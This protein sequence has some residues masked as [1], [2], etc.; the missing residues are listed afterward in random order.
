MGYT[1]QALNPSFVHQSSVYALSIV[2]IVASVIV[3]CLRFVA[4][5]QQKAPL[6]ADDYLM[7]AAVV[8]L[9]AMGS[10]LIYGAAH[11]ALGVSMFSLPEQ[12]IPEIAMLAG[13]IEYTSYIIDVVN[14]ALTKLSLIFFYRR[15]F[16]T[17]SA[18]TAYFNIF[19]LVMAVIVGL[20][21]IIMVFVFIF[22]C[23][24]HMNVLWDGTSEQEN[25]CVE[26]LPLMFGFSLTDMIFDFVILLMP[27]PKVWH[28]QLTVSR[29]ISLCFV[30]ALGGFACIGALMRL[31]WVIYAWKG[32]FD[33]TLDPI[34]VVT[35]GLWWSMLES[36]IAAVA[37]CALTLRILFTRRALESVVNSIRSAVS[38]ASMGS[39]QASQAKIVD[40]S[41][42]SSLSLTPGHNHNSTTS[43]AGTHPFTNPEDIEAQ[44]NI[45]RGNIRVQKT[46]S[47]DY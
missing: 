21:G 2:L 36:G 42:A 34:I 46:I 1:H 30:F 14:L 43:S 19:T 15:I 6:L 12:R 31:V 9:L 10:A 4:R 37:A 35:T 7:L 47:S 3:T 39:Q 25:V 8:F 38:L 26:T 29:K 45:P 27:L 18:R 5:R 24:T 41:H 23:G 22:Q 13:Q 32:D 17:P 33:P 11:D 16:C 28:L 40:D 20:W 44:R